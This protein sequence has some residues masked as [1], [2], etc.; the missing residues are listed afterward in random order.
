MAGLVQ[1]LTDH[2]GEEATRALLARGGL[3]LEEVRSTSAWASV[4]QVEVVMEAA[5]AL[6][7]SEESFAEANGYRLR[8]SLGPLVHLTWAARPAAILDIAVR[9][10]EL[11]SRVSGGGPVESGPGRMRI[12][13]TSKYKEKRVLCLSRQ[14]VL[15]AVPTIWGLP[16]ATARDI[17]CLGWGD[18]CCEFEITWREPLTHSWLVLGALVGALVV[19]AMRLLLR[20]SYEVTWGIPLV[21][22]ALGHVSDVRNRRRAEVRE[23][24]ELRDNISALT[25]EADDARREFGELRSR[26]QTWL[27]HLQ[28]ELEERAVAWQRVFAKFEGRANDDRGALRAVSHDLASPLM[29]LQMALASVRSSVARGEP[30]DPTILDEQEHAAARVE[31]LLRDL[32]ALSWERRGWGWV[33]LI[34]P[35][36]LTAL[37]DSL[38]RRLRARALGRSLRLSV[39]T[40]VHAPAVIE[41]QRILLDRIIDHLL[42]NAVKYTDK[43]SVSIELGGSA[44]QLVIKIAD[45]G[46]G[47]APERLESAFQDASASADRTTG[48]GDGLSR[49]VPLV[50]MLQARLEVASGV[51]QGTTFWLYLFADRSRERP[52][53]TNVVQVRKRT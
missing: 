13:Y 48:D 38:S 31:S 44:E 36:E 17:K 52:P 26:E 41:T 24:A 7:G 32:S 1:F 28:S 51:G 18:D 21:L 9:S 30:I 35:L 49:L 2:H 8:E 23:N 11:F 33:E 34:E 6:I 16:R 19:F 5:L 25:R 22:A 43:G 40:D 37:A 42:T 15:S 53:S 3:T 47:I 12:V 50:A 29:A 4:A 10:L 20:V 27:S 45:T 14:G 46:R 39:T